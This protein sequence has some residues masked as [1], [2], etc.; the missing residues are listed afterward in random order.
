MTARPVAMSAI[1]QSWSG[2]RSYSE[3]SASP[4]ATSLNQR[5]PHNPPNASETPPTS[6]AA[7]CR[8]YPIRLGIPHAHE[9]GPAPTALHAR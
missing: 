6:A 3:S 1:S 8:P 4:R 7:G 9:P 2:N 5:L